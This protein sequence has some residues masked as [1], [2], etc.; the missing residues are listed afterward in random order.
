MMSRILSILT[1]EHDARCVLADIRAMGRK[2]FR[3]GLEDMQTAITG[4]IEGIR[5]DLTGQSLDLDVHLKRGDS[6]GGTGHLEVHVAEVVLV[7]E[8]VRQDRDLVA[9]L[10]ETHGDSGN[11]SLERHPGVH[12]AQATATNGGHRTRT[13]RLQ[14][15]AD[16]SKCVR[17]FV[18]G[19]QHD[20]QGTLGQLAVTDFA[21]ALATKRLDLAGA[22]RREVVVE[23]EGVANIA[24][25][26]V[27]ALRVGLGPKGRGDDRLGLT[28]LEQG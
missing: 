22:V 25:D 4:L 9:L 24:T 11:R 20:P 21:A 10:H 28:A 3:H 13:I 1:D 14:G 18:L 17:E 7:A 15:V 8:D 16:N 26:G 5:E 19:G 23:Q 2:N 27:Q 12:E 6:L